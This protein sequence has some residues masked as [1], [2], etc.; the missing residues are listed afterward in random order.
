MWVFWLAS[1]TALAPTRR[2]FLLASSASSVKPEDS[3]NSALRAFE[4]GDYAQSLELWTALTERS[5]DEGLFWSNRG[6]V[7]LI[8]GSAQA[9]LGV[10]PTGEAAE[11]LE[12]AVSSFERALEN[13]DASSISLNNLGNAQAAMLRWDRAA[14]AYDRA[15]AAAIKSQA[16]VSIAVA[17]RAQ[18]AMELDDLADAEKRVA[19][20]LRKDPNF[21][22]G[23]AL[24]A[25]IKYARGDAA[26]AE[27]SFASLCRP[28]VSAP[29]QFNAPIKG[30]G[31]TD[32]CELYSS[33][34]IVLGRWTP[35]ATAAYDAFLSSRTPSARIAA[36]AD[37]F[38]Y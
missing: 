33:R 29:N 9:T 24:M 6:T 14:D 26:G 8:L 11:L 5:P 2:V 7:E 13:G 30:L 16:S 17:N 27:A 36:D 37:P 25:A 28:T 21:L 10:R 32:W 12:A 3:V 38:S 35:K 34:D 1:A 4:R 22:D 15:T 18:V 19:T 23:R 20:L 31:G